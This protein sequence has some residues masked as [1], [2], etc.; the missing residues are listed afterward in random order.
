MVVPGKGDLEDCPECVLMSTPEGT[1]GARRMTP[2]LSSLRNV[3]GGFVTANEEAGAETGDVDDLLALDGRMIEA[4]TRGGGGASET[5]GDCG[6]NTPNN[7][8]TPLPT[9]GD[10]ATCP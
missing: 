10:I 5:N 8:R 6:V 1:G 7:L 2:A 3:A 4:G 9:H